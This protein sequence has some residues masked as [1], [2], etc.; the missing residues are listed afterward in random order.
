MIFVHCTKST[1][2]TGQNQSRVFS[3]PGNNESFECSI[4]ITHEQRALLLKMR[5]IAIFKGK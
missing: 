2:A 3:L 4:D 5:S 1:H